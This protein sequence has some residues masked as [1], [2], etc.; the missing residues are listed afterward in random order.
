MALPEV[1]SDLDHKIIHDSRG[2]I[3][4]VV[5]VDSVVTS[6]DNILGTRQGE[7]AMLPE[8]ASTIGD[9]LFEPIDDNLLDFMAREVKRVIE[10]WDDRV[11]VTSVNFT[12][13]PDRNTV[14]MN[15]Q[16]RVG[17]Y[18]QI[19]EYQKRLGRA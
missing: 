2:A 12:S 18:E 15:I 17:G 4:K 7:R 14:H 5:N 16:F 1:W 10:R 13:D 6:I 19:F 11:K 9:M 3:K 8:F